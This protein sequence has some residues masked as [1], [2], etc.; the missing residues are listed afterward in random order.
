MARWCRPKD[1]SAYLDGALPARK[2]SRV[3]RHL[4]S[5]ARCRQELAKLERV[6]ELFCVWEEV[7]AP[8]YFAE[9]VLHRLESREDSVW[10]VRV[11][12][13]FG[14]LAATVA[15]AAVL[16]VAGVLVHRS[17]PDP[18]PATV[19]DYLRGSLDSGV[20]EVAGLQESSIPR[21]L[22]LS[23]VLADGP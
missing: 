9:R 23:L 15:A 11:G 6:R 16:L 1:L 14:R 13:G 21:D 5:C 4:V 20:A 18:E 17:L 7:G 3:K 10:M 8:D 12:W 22:V 19:A 2:A